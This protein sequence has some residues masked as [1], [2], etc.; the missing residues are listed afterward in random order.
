MLQLFRKLKLKYQR[1]RIQWQ[2]KSPAEKWDCIINLGKIFG[3]WIGV[4]MFGDMK[5]VWYSA[6]PGICGVIF[7]LLVLY[8]LQYDLRRGAFVKAMECTYV[9]GIVVE[10]SGNVRHF[11]FFK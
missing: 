6:L 11:A 8:T 2:V 10:V 4:R 3:D 5:I 1:I 7:F 9:V